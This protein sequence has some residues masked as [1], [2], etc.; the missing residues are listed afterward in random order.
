MGIIE[1]TFDKA[2]RLRTSARTL[3]FQ[4]PLY[5]SVSGEERSKQHLTGH[6][7]KTLSWDQFRAAFAKA[8]LPFQ[9]QKVRRQ[10][11]PPAGGGR[12]A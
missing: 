10:I 12:C 9:N 6:N 8:L 7:T 2:S 1:A 3:E 4:P 11:R 5:L